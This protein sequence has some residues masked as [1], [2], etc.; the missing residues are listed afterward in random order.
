MGYQYF[1]Y[2][3]YTSIPNIVYPQAQM[4]LNLDLHTLHVK[5]L[6]FKALYNY[7]VRALIGILNT[8]YDDLCYYCK[9][10]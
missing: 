8:Y 10:T 9:F 2:R 7:K 4:G 1:D 6:V 5:Y 3:R